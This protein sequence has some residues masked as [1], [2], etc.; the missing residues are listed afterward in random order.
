MMPHGYHRLSGH[1]G[2]GLREMHTATGLRRKEGYRE[3]P[4]GRK[5]PRCHARKPH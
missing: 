1:D 5:N 4:G 3:F 2:N